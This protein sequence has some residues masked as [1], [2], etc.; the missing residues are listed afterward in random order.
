MADIY[1]NIS[2]CTNDIYMDWYMMRNDSLPIKIANFK[3]I[4]FCK[5][6]KNK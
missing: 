5:V 6:L 4:S 1:T 2:Y 3:Q